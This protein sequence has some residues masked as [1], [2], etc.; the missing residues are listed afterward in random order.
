MWRKNIESS[1]KKKKRRILNL[2]HM[3]MCLDRVKWSDPMK[4]VDEDGGGWSHTIKG[5]IIYTYPKS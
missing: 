3:N 1:T 4:G 5:H 2:G